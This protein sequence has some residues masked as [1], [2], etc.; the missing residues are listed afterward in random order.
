MSKELIAAAKKRNNLDEIELLLEEGAAIDFQ[1]EAGITALHEATL[2]LDTITMRFLLNNK[3]KVGLQ[4]KQGQSALHH[5]Y[6][7][8]TGDNEQ[9]L[10]PA[11]RLLLEFNADPN[12]TD[13]DGDTL[14][15]WSAYNGYINIARELFSHGANFTD[16]VMA[17]AVNGGNQAMLQYLEDNFANNFEGSISSR[18]AYSV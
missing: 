10:L 11:I 18:S 16:A 4:D 5:V 6:A 7:E 9:D 8:Y 2:N 14:L 12:Q 1:N 3:A 15:K 17:N 13:S